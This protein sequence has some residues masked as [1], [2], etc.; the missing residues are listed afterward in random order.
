ME[1]YIKSWGGEEWDGTWVCHHTADP[2]TTQMLG[3]QTPLAV[4]NPHTTFDAPKTL[5]IAYCQ[6]ETLPLT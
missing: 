1:G 4:E 2:S 5:L 6:P 3:A